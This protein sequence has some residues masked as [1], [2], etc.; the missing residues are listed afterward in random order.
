MVCCVSSVVQYVSRVFAGPF[1]KYLWALLG[2]GVGAEEQG[3]GHAQPHH[4][5]RLGK[6]TPQLLA[7][8]V[9]MH[10]VIKLRFPEFFFFF[11]NSFT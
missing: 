3:R 2:D 7:P 4:G 10:T 9:Y 8:A 1:T 11:P 5:E 6:F